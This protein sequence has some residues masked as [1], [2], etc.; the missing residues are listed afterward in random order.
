[1]FWLLQGERDGLVE[2]EGP[3]LGGGGLREH[4]H[5]GVGS[6]E[7][8]VVAGQGGEVVEQSAEA[9]QPLAAFVAVA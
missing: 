5:G 8:D 9:V 7:A 4:G 2:F 6:G 1:M 3:S